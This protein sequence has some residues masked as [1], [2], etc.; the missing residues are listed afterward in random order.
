MDSAR[1]FW[2]DGAVRAQGQPFVAYEGNGLGFQFGHV[3][4]LGDRAGMGAE[5]AAIHG[6]GCEAA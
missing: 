2:C 4:L 1:L 5:G 6:G 3:V